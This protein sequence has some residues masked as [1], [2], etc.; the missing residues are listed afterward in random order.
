MSAPTPQPSG[1]GTLRDT[2]DAFEAERDTLAA[3]IAELEAAL[4]E[5]LTCSLP[6][7]ISGM[8]IIERARAALAPRKLRP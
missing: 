6:R 2:L 7:D 3:R 4:A 8:G 1:S 5:L